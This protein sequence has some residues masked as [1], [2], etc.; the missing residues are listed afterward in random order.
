MR[1][2]CRGQGTEEACGGSVCGWCRWQRDEGGRAGGGSVQG[3]GG[4]A[5][6]T[7]GAEREV[8]VGGTERER[9]DGVRYRERSDGV[10]Y[11]ERKK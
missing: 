3:K 1:G 2:W 6:Q 11:R 9:S 10:R 4:V 5:G 8:T 7:R